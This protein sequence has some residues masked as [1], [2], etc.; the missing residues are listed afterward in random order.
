MITWPL[1]VDVSQPNLPLESFSET[2]KDSRGKICA[3]GKVEKDT[4]WGYVHNV[5]YFSLNSWQNTITAHPEV[6]TPNTRVWDTYYRTVLPLMLQARGSEILHASAVSSPQ[7]LVALC[8]RSE[9][10]KSTL[11]Y[12]LSQRNYPLWADDAVVFDIQKQVMA[13]QLPFSIRLRQTSAEF[14]Q[15]PDR[16][17]RQILT[18][19]THAD[20]PSLPLRC[21]FVLERLTSDAQDIVKVRKLPPSDA[22]SAV[23]PH[24]YSFSLEN[25]RRKQQMMRQYLDFV[26]KVP[27]FALAFQ[28]G[29]HHVETILGEIEITLLGLGWKFNK[30]G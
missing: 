1:K 22:F 2:W 9:T 7:G 23:L 20:L 11:A 14:Y 26:N 15:Q 28:A 18:E 29:L 3:Y 30:T 21:L 5:G 16:D 10:G 4:C 24:A 6:D 12:G 25:Q 13:L 19:N 8:A 17:H 27:V